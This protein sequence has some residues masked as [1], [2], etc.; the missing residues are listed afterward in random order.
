MRLQVSLKRNLRSC[1]F[2][3]MKRE[4]D[5]E[6]GPSTKRTRS[7]DDID[8]RLLIPSKVRLMKLKRPNP[9]RRRRIFFTL[10]V[11]FVYRLQDP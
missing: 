1:V 8:V 5:A 9:N 7:G 10:S 2:A 6:M 4:A 3:G 11:R